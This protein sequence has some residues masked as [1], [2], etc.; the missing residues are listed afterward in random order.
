MSAAMAQPQ[1]PELEFDLLLYL[2][3]LLAH[4]KLVV[5]S[6]LLGA[7]LA[8]AYSMTLPDV[9]EAFVRVNVVDSS[10]P[11]GIKPDERR[12]SEVLTL[13]EHGFVMGTSHDNHLDVMLAKLRSRR[14]TVEFIN[15]HGID[16]HLYPQYWVSGEY[17]PVEGEDLDSGLVFKRFVEEIRVIEHNPET[18]LVTIRM[19]W[20]DQTL[21]RDWANAYVAAF[22]QH[23]RFKTLDE[24]QRKQAYLRSELEKSDVVDLQK[25][26]YRLVE[27]QTAIAMLANSR[28]EFALEVIDPATVPFDRFSPAPRRMTAFAFVSGAML[29]C[30]FVIGRIILQRIQSVLLLTGAARPQENLS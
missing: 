24:V 4:W 25:S 13:V 7:S 23:I 29:A 1:L 10:D 26:I 22:N 20:T 5:A 6:A 3:A 28:D 12:A 16:R 17:Q 27:A 30:F 2:G 18:D 15:D 14:F 9:F 19:R 11:G 21:A 8:A